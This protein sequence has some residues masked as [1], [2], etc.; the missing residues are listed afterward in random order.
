[1]STATDIA[2]GEN[3]PSAHPRVVALLSL[4]GLGVTLFLLGRGI[5]YA[6]TDSW[7]APIMLSP[8]N[9]TVL[10]INIKLNEQMV[11][12]AK[13]QHDLGRID[14]DVRGVDQA[15]ARLQ[16]LDTDGKEAM[17]WTSLATKEQSASLNEQLKSLN[18]Q[19][20][21]LASMLS[22]ENGLYATAQKNARAGLLSG[23]DEERELQILNQ[24]QLTIS[25]NERDI[26]QTR[27][28]AD[29]FSLAANALSGS[30]S[31]ANGR[32]KSQ[33][34]FGLIPEVASSVDRDVRVELEV[35]KLQAERRAL[36]AERDT[37]IEALARMDEIFKQLKDRPIYRAI[38]ARTDVG[39]VPYT[40]LEGVE[41]GSE[42]ID[43]TWIVF[44]CHKVGRVSE[45]LS[46][47]VV[48]QDPW[49]DVAR[50]QYAI[51]ELTDREASKEKVLRARKARH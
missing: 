25:Q 41:A 34:A 32:A 19:K 7:L 42:L 5:Y 24:L 48:A 33:V 12:H 51:L 10:A 21:M 1:V 4:L 45:V 39:F 14:D 31:A 49:S 20:A 26:A 23:Q 30:S 18:K 50:G 47:E 40:Q 27:V 8:D 37:A 2:S 29:Q 38:Q 35:I 15:I 28:M 22:S 6:I 43:C 16:A 17:H 44:A 11:E 36:I 9:D 13:L 3:K 46:G